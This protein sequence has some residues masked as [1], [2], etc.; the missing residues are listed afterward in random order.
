M[1]GDAGGKTN[2]FQ[3]KTAVTLASAAR[4]LSLGGH[5]DF[6][7]GQVSMRLPGRDHLFIKGAMKGFD[8]C[9]P[10][11]IVVSSLDPS[12]ESHSLAP[13]ELPLHQAIYEARPDIN[14][15]VHSHAPHGLIFGATDLPLRPVSHEGAYFANRL[16]RFTETSDTVLDLETANLVA[17]A[18]GESPALLLRNHG[19]VVVGKSIQHAVVFAHMLERACR[20]QLA[21]EQLGVDYHWSGR[22]DVEKKRNFVHSDLSV[23]SY[24]IYC[25][26]QVRRRWPEVADW[27]HQ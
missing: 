1:S 23:R 27:R 11:D 20:L 25:L 26:S 24:W 5:D 4:S 15:I 17:G 19:S 2:S 21:T 12:V 16:P 10:S 8:E 14:A 7:Q 9:V 18:L 13:P 22:G 3:R 6:N